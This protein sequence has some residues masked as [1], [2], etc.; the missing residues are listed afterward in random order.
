[1][2]PFIFLFHYLLVYLTME[3]NKTDEELKQMT[4]EQ[5]FEYLDAKAAFLKQHTR[6]LS[7]YLTKKYASISSAVTNSEFDYDGVTKIA[8]EN[9]SASMAIFMNRVKDAT[10][11]I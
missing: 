7:G 9:E 3:F 4:E 10:N 2:F 8:K 1:M 6:P 11:G 5:L